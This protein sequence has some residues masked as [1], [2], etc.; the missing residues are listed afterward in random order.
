MFC[1]Y[2]PHDSSQ[3]SA[4]PVHCDPISIPMIKHCDHKTYGRQD[5]F[6][7]MVPEGGESMKVE[8]RNGGSE[9]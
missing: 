3:L 5:I 9:S 1:S 6:G 8:L 7:L 2:E 4:M